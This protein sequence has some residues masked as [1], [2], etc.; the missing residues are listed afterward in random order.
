MTSP[1]QVQQLQ[2]EEALILACFEE[3]MQ[4]VEDRLFHDSVVFHSTI[5]HHDVLQLPTVNQSTHTRSTH[6]NQSTNTYSTHFNQ[7][8][9]SSTF[10][11]HHANQS[12]STFTMY[13]SPSSHGDYPALPSHSTTPSNTP[14]GQALL[15]PWDQP[16]QVIL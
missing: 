11:I 9:S 14:A 5:S 12:T 7:S 8:G 2:M 13:Q 3:M 10:P 4:E 16:L 1:L 15:S 6:V